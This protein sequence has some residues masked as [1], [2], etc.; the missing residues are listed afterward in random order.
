NL[1]LLMHHREIDRTELYVADELFLCGTMS[2]LLPITS[3][4]RIPV[5]DGMPGPLTLTLQGHYDD[6]VRARGD[7]S[8]WCSWM[9][10]AHEEVPA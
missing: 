4:D 3:V 10:P 9:V 5:G 7:H 8:E 1:G 2:E 6:V